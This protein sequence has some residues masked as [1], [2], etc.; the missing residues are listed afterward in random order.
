MCVSSS[1]KEC[2][3]S[4]ATKYDSLVFNANV[5]K[6]KIEPIIDLVYWGIDTEDNKI[7]KLPDSFGF[8]VGADPH[9]TLIL[10]DIKYVNSKHSEL[11]SKLLFLTIHSPI[12]TFGTD[13]IL[14]RRYNFVLY[15]NINKNHTFNLIYLKAEVNST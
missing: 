9:F 5:I 2:I 6:V 8:K 12:K 4:E 10:E 1:K 13:P 11:S 3:F 7:L 15:Y 14:G